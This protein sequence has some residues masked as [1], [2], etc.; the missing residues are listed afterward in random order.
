MNSKIVINTVEN[1][2]RFTDLYNRYW[3]KVYSFTKLYIISDFDAEE[4]V[5]EVFLKVWENLDKINNYKDIDGYLFI[6][7]RNIV[8]NQSRKKINNSF[9]KYTLSE[10]FTIGE[11][12]SEHNKMISKDLKEYILKVIE[13]L[14]PRQKEIFKLSR[15]KKKT[16]KEIAESLKIAPKTVERH[17][18]E[19]LKYLKKKIFLF[20][21][22]YV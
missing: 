1:N 16:Y 6:I 17:I 14:P 21:L 19:A 12:D 8:F 22:L 18:G 11:E 4:A 20:T 13:E 10:A 3:S 2:L 15:I 7:T 9:L 5:Q